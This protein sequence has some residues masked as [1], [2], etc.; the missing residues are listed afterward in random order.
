MIGFISGDKIYEF[1]SLCESLKYACKF[2]HFSAI[3]KTR[4]LRSLLIS[5]HFAFHTVGNKDFF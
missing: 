4:S 2:D 3:V 1:L 5:E